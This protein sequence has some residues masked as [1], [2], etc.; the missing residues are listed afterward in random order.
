MK[1]EYR[2]FRSI[3][4]AALALSDLDGVSFDPMRKD[5]QRSVIPD[6]TL[7]TLETE[8]IEAPSPLERWGLLRKET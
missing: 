2:Y 5:D 8:W 7:R 3:S 4:K 6:I 1:A